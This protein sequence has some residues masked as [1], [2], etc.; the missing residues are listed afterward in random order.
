[1]GPRVSLIR[2]C[3]SRVLRIPPSHYCPDLRAVVP[4]PL[5]HRPV[6][7]HVEYSCTQTH[8]FTRG[9]CTAVLSS[10]ASS[11]NVKAQVVSSPHRRVISQ[12]DPW[13]WGTR[14]LFGTGTPCLTA[15]L[16]QR[17]PLDPSKHPSHTQCRLRRL[18]RLRRHLPPPPS[19][20]SSAGRPWPCPARARPSPDPPHPAKTNFA[21]LASIGAMPASLTCI[22]NT[23]PASP[24]NTPQPPHDTPPK[25][26]TLESPQT[27]THDELEVGLRTTR[28]NHSLVLLQ[29]HSPPPCLFSN[30]DTL[31]LRPIRSPRS[32]E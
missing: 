4:G 22:T 24:H 20:S 13:R 14:W 3:I 27:K 17:V 19:P 5:L 11:G 32:N 7:V 29:L 28:A 30:T 26:Y 16:S 31:P 9:L 6:W 10:Q 21:N 1:M 15:E 8:W 25:V 18:C 2:V 12:G 23:V